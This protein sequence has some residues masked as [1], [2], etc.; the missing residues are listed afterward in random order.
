MAKKASLKGVLTLDIGAFERGLSK[1]LSKSKNFAREVAAYASGQVVAKGLAELSQSIVNVSERFEEGV[2]SAYEMGAALQETASRTGMASG[3]IMILNQVFKEAGVDAGNLGGLVNKM[4]RFIDGAADSSSAAAGRLG[5]LG[6]SYSRL[7]GMAPDAQ[8]KAIGL[9]IENVSDPARRAA[10][11]IAIFGRAGGELL[12]VFDQLKEGDL[13]GIMAS[14]GRQS[15]I[16]S[17]NSGMFKAISNLAGHMSN[18]S[19][20]FFVGMGNALSERAFLV[21]SKLDKMDFSAMG[22]KV[23]A[24]IGTFADA[25]YGAFKNPKAVLGLFEDVLMDGGARFVNY[26]A[27]GLV[28]NGLVLMD[29]LKMGA[30]LAEALGEGFIG[31]LLKG[32]GSLIGGLGRAS[33]A[34]S[35]GLEFAFQHGLEALNSGWDNIFKTVKDGM[36]WAFDSAVRILKTAVGVVWNG[37]KTVFQSIFHALA[38]LPGLA[39]KTKEILIHAFDSNPFVQDTKKALDA[40]KGGYHAESYETIY[41][42]QLA[43]NRMVGMGQS[44][45]S[46]GDSMVADASQKAKAALP[47]FVNSYMGHIHRPNQDYMGVAGYDAKVA[48]GVGS[49]VANGSIEKNLPLKG[50]YNGAPIDP[51]SKLAYQLKSQMG[52][53]DYYDTIYQGQTGADAQASHEAYSQTHFTP[54]AKYMQDLIGQY[55]HDAVWGNPYLKMPGMLDASGMLEKNAHVS[56]ASGSAN[57]TW[58]DVAWAAAAGHHIQ[59]ASNRNAGM[60]YGLDHGSYGHHFVNKAAEARW[61][62]SHGQGEKTAA[63]IGDLGRKIDYPAWTTKDN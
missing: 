13:P 27:N 37:L 41:N 26:L 38:M 3:Q 7:A 5:D 61:K 25:V 58:Y 60:G 56:Q 50:Y 14:I 49:L 40:P 39:H 57:K 18:K 45:S 53:K 21:L 51:K 52:A 54:S 10:D 34:F 42:R 22:E 4:Q 35:A 15:K 30:T 59:G 48:A 33:V 36:V 47:A 24:A 46:K 2:K 6:I 1:A 63:N 8:F 44:I 19:S 20:G 32:V 12:P 55:G 16:L 43:S 28:R 31:G 11:A 17:D 9:A 29:V 23:G 62:K